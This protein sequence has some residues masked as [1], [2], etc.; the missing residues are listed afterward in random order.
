MSDFKIKGKI[1]YWGISEATEEYLRRANA[2]RP[3]TAIE[4]RYSMMA[5]WHETISPYVKN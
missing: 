2:V 5:R 1:R 4:N 3:V